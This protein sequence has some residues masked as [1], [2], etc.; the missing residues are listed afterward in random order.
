LR[1]SGCREISSTVSAITIEIA[2][3]R[4]TGAFSRLH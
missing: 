2:S 4:K 1:T 3:A